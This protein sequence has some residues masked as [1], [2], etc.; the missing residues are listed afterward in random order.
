[1]SNDV[2]F[3]LHHGDFLAITHFGDEV[4]FTFGKVIAITV[5]HLGKHVGLPPS[6]IN[7]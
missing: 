6:D 4:G 3:T 1:M 7:T 2:G 5:A